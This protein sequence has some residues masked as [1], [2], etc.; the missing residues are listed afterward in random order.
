MTPTNIS[1]A[2]IGGGMGGLTAALTLL[3]AG[4]D[5]HVFEQAG[6]VSEIGAGVQISPNASRVLHGLG[7]E[8]ALARTGVKPLAW[9]QRRWNDGQTLLRTPLALAMEAHF[10]FPHY[11]MHRADVIDALVAALPAERLHAGHRFAGL[12]D[13][14]DRVDVQFEN[15]MHF[16]AHALIGADGIHSAVRRA[17][18]GREDARFTGCVAYRGLVPAERLAQLQLEVTAQVWM[19]PGQHF[20]HYFVRN[21]ELVNF[22]AVVDQ[23]DWALESWTMRADAAEASTAFAAWHPQ[24]RAILAAVDQTYKWALFDRQ[25]MPHWSAGRVTL[26][27]DACHAMLPFM[28]QGAAQAIEDAATLAACLRPCNAHELPEALRH[29]ETQ[30]LARTAKIQSLSSA[31]KARFHLPDGEAQRERDAQMQQG[32]TDWSPQAVAWLY[33]HDAWSTAASPP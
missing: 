16:E 14:G 2:V 6:A 7:L 4:F 13:H 26:L 23:S 20:V 12:V 30:R 10:G 33:G 29:Y 9:H 25:P 19:G 31:N 5:V 28:A 15:G 17:V 8:N 27:G 3:Q 22:V 24:V 1:I 21:R 18:F 32:S 11:Q